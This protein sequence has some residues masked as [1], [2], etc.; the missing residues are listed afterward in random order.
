[1]VGDAGCGGCWARAG[2]GVLGESVC[3]VLGERGAWRKLGGHAQAQAQARAHQTP[4][5]R[6]SPPAP[7]IVVEGDLARSFLLSAAAEVARAPRALRGVC[8]GLT[9]GGAGSG[10]LRATRVARLAPAGIGAGTMYEQAPERRASAV[11]R[12]DSGKVDRGWAKG[13]TVNVDEGED[14]IQPMLVK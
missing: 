12:R 8:H 13:D 1:M 5:T 6:L 4:E 7:S 11:G 3:G 9:G 14:E 10:P 2:R